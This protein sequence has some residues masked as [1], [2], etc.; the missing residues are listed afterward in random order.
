H[1]LKS[2]LPNIRYKN[3]RRATADVTGTT[4][5]VIRVAK[6]PGAVLPCTEPSLFL[7]DAEVDLVVSLNLLSQLPV[8]PIAYLER[9]GVH[10]PQAIA[11]FARHLIA[12][13]LGYLQ[14]F[15]C[16]VALITDVEK[17][18]LN[19]ADKLVGKSSLL[20]GVP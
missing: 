11:A 2:W 1:P 4:E 5:E 17:L 8:V 3:L 14:R 20:H 12:S 15:P 7:D 10:A 9:C 19:R 16:T 18:T 6:L 13:H